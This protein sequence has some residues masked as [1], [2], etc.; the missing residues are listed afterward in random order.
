MNSCKKVNSADP[1]G[2]P[3]VAR[4]A[5]LMHG[6]HHMDEFSQASDCIIQQVSSCTLNLPKLQA[7]DA[8]RAARG[9]SKIGACCAMQHRSW[10]RMVIVCPNQQYAQHPE[11]GTPLNCC[12]RRMA[13]EQA[14]ANKALLSE[15]QPL[16][17]QRVLLAQIYR[18]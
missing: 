8:Q 17:K 9:D 18:Q 15:W 14:L 7:N 4:N 10:K 11:C 12:P 5:V 13:T 2:E 6:D 16:G 1:T 3:N